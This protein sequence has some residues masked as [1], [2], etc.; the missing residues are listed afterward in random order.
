VS[1]ATRPDTKGTIVAFIQIIEYRTDHAAEMLTVADEWER[2]TEGK[3]WV[4][5]RVLCQDR[6]DPRHFFN[7][8]F[9]E[10]YEAAMVNSNL[11]ETD[12]LS[13][14]YMKLADGPPTFH[15][16]EVVDDRE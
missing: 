10:S 2:A 4:L 1:V 7:V 12:A 6:E 9:F 5:R 15:N 16:L 14:R 13:K 3:R 11:P 8:V